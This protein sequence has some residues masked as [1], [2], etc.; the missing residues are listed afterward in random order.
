M[1]YAYHVTAAKN[2]PSIAAYGLLPRIGPNAKLLK[3]PK[4]AIYLF[5]T[6]E[7]LETAWDTWLGD[8]FDVDEQVALLKVE[9]TGPTHSEV[10]YELMVFEP[11]PVAQIE[12]LTRDLDA[13]PAGSL[14]RLA[15][16]PV[17]VLP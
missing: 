1:Q 12:L 5:P 2:L 11:I 10:E 15:T 16:Q 6:I 8:L 17:P 13:V 9:L 14:A 7:D 4:P 3:E